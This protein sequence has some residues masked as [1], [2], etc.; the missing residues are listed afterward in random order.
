VRPNAPV[1]ALVAP[2]RA[3]TLNGSSVIGRAAVD[4]VRRAVRTTQAKDSRAFRDFLVGLSTAILE[5]QPA[6]APLVSLTSGL[7]SS[8]DGD[9]PIL[10]AREAVLRAADTFRDNTERAVANVSAHTDPLLPHG[11]VVL[12]LSSSSTV[13]AALERW[14]DE[15]ELRVICL[16]SRPQLEGIHLARQLSEAGLEVTVAV[17]AAA[18]NMVAE[19][20]LVLLGGDSLGDRGIMN[21]IGSSALVSLARGQNVPIHILLDRSKLLPPGFPQLVEDPRPGQEIMEEEGR[22]RIWNHYFE[23]FPVDSVASIVTEEGITSPFEVETIRSSISV[24]MELKAWAEA[25]SR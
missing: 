3:D 13:R 5:A 9:D 23:L 17:D 6:M 15:R 2:L 8:F 19:A 1:D 24:P 14:G 25:R 20:D 12:T 4:V 21:K 10:G 16:E 11:A 7:L 22:I 18:G